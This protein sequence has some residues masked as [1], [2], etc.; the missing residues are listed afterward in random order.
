[1]LLLEGQEFGLDDGQHPRL[2]GEDV[3][4]ILDAGDEFVVVGLDPVTFEG[5]ELVEAKFE[6]GISLGLGEGVAA[7][8]DARLAA[9]RTVVDGRPG[10]LGPA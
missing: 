4:E 3:E 5:G 8:D 9:D 6:D 1:V 7:V 2:A 10:E